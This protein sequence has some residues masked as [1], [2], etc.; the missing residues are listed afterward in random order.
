MQFTRSFH[1]HTYIPVAKFS[2]GGH[3]VSVVVVV[4]EVVVVV[5]VVVVEVVA[6][7]VVVDVVA[8]VEVLDWHLSSADAAQKKIILSGQPLYDLRKTFSSL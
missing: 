2:A 1:I 6:L 7:V 4:V 5:L 8:V 3:G